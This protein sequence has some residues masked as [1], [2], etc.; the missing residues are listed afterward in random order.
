VLSLGVSLSAYCPRFAMEPVLGTLPDGSQVAGD[1]HA[2]LPAAACST[3]VVEAED[4]RKEGRLRVAAAMKS[5]DWPRMTAELRVILQLEPEWVDGYLALRHALLKCEDDSGALSALWAA[6]RVAPEMKDFATTISKVSESAIAG[7][8]L[9]EVGNDVQ[10]L[11]EKLAEQKP[12]SCWD[13][14]VAL[15][16]A[17][18]DVMGSTQILYRST[19]TGDLLLSAAQPL[20]LIFLDVDGVLNS[21]DSK[22]TGVISPVFLS[23]LREIIAATGA[24]VV[25]SSTWRNWPQL[26]VLIM[27]ALPKGSVVGQTP[28]EDEQVWRNDVRPREIRDFL[29]QIEA[30][31]GH[32][33]SWAAIDDM[34]LIRQANAL[35]CKDPSMIDFAERL[36]AH[37]VKTEKDSG[38]QDPQAA[39]LL[40][41]LS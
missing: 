17:S 4:A 18:Q 5:K 36:V 38:L 39:H 29:H 33:T 9:K 19:V 10:M 16:V 3:P 1:S 14:C 41:L 37:F 13:P 11:A 26:R 22:N 34:D 8:D 12:A 28:L 7:G 32:V 15:D 6:L 24:S 23:R 27:A 20:R 21:A 25:L 35:A 31:I 30:N 40:Q 2:G